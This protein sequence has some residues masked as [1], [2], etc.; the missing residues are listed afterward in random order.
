MSAHNNLLII[1]LD[2]QDAEV[3]WHLIAIAIFF[4]LIKLPGP[5]YP[6]WGRIFIPHFANG[7]LLR[8]LWFM[9]LWYKRPKISGAVLPNSLVN[10][11]DSEIE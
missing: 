11:S 9:F 2:F 7:A 10:G 5:Y 4:T 6:Y 8:T 3:P 1:W